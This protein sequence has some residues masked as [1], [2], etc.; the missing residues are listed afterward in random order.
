MKAQCTLRSI[1]LSLALCSPLMSLAAYSQT[2]TG[3]ILG[4][5]ADQSGALLPRVKITTKNVDTGITRTITT[6]AEGRY[7]FRTLP[8]GRY[9]VK[10]ERTG[11]SSR[12]RSG[13]ELTIGRDA[14]IDFHLEVGQIQDVV[15][16]TGEATLIETTTSAL[17]GFVGGARHTR[18]AAQWQRRFPIDYL[19]G[20]GRQHGRYYRRIRRRP[21]AG[22]ST[23][24][25]SQSTSSAKRLRRI[26]PA[27]RRARGFMKSTS[28]SWKMKS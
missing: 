9:E 5:A 13:I 8:V 4:T 3:T 19:A 6:D 17:A 10:A 15:S 12:I 26:M 2:T 14:V 24:T 7:E 22:Q 21:A 28:D 25:E 18:I 11:F 23:G 27:A 16:I 20:R 1:L